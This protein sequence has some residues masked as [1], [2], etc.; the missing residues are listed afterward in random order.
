M[1]WRQCWC[2]IFISFSGYC[3]NMRSFLC[4]LQGYLGEK[5]QTSLNADKVH[6]QYELV[7]GTL[8][9]IFAFHSLENQLRIA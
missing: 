6:D 5:K 8:T 1:Y 7:G 9:H 4:N 3:H 2:C